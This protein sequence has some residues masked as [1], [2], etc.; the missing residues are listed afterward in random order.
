MKKTYTVTGMHCD[1]CALLIEEELADAGVKAVCNYKT[2][3]LV[4]EDNHSVSQDS[5]FALVKGIGYT[6]TV[7]P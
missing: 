1:S 3:T 7:K 5:L 4:V 6:L 2:N